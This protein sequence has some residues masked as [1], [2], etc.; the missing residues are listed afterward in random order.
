MAQNYDNIKNF[1]NLHTMIRRVYSLAFV[2][3][4]IKQKVKQKKFAK[5][6]ILCESIFNSLGTKQNFNPVRQAIPQ[7]YRNLRNPEK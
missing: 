4:S 3:T 6:L 5:H 7:H 2:K 1:P